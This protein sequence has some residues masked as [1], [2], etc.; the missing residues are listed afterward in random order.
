MPRN[1]AEPRSYNVRI[2]QPRNLYSH[3]TPNSILKVDFHTNFPIGPLAAR[4]ADI[5]PVRKIISNNCQIRLL[6][7]QTITKPPL[8]PLSWVKHHI[9][10]VAA[11]F[12]D[13]WYLKLRNLHELSLAL[14]LHD[15]SGWYLRITAGK[16]LFL[17][18]WHPDRPNTS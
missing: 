8:K 9:V 12:E 3:S 17:Q 4:C 7:L 16:L 10:I 2:F 11:R 5:C 18:R 13:H 1:L 15:S 14:D 6:D